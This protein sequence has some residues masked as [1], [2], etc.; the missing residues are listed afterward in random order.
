MFPKNQKYRL[1]LK[2]LR[3]RKYQKLYRGQMYLMILKYH[4]YRLYHLYL[5]DLNYLKYL[6]YLK[7][8]KFR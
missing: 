7:N 3:T 4:L 8:L 6:K 2:G 5:K 1:Y